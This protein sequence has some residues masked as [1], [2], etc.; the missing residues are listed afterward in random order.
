[1]TMGTFPPLLLELPKFYVAESTTQKS[2]NISYKGRNSWVSWPLMGY[3]TTPVS[4][5]IVILVVSK[6][7]MNKSLSKSS[8]KDLIT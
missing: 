1:M 4:F 8:Y 2:R 6:S 3:L 5:L 7:T